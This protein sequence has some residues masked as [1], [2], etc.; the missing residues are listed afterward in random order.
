MN[1]HNPYAAPKASFEVQAST[2]CS[3]DGKILIV[4]QGHGLPARCVKC[5]EPAEM[6]R[7][8]KFAWHHPGW[9]LFLPVNIILYAI[10][11]T[12]AQKKAKVAIGLCDSHRGRRRN[13]QLTAW[14]ILALG[15]AAI[16]LGIASEGPGDEAVMLASLGGLLLLAAAVVGIIGSRVLWPSRITSEEVRLKGCC[17]AF[18]DTFPSV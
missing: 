5:N 2:G 4:P 15:L 16:G 17:P 1:P 12:F 7:P 13:F 8:R 18:L 3:R 6:D 11:A 9:Y 14:A 10:I